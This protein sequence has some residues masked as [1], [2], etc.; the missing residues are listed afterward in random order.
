LSHKSYYLPTSSM[1]PFGVLDVKHNHYLTSWVRGSP[2][3]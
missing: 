3:S 2:R 1:E